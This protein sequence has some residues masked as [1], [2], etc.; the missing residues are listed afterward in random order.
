M[1]AQ[2][3]AAATVGEAVASPSVTVASAGAGES[4]AAEPAPHP[5]GRSA[6]EETVERVHRVTYLAENSKSSPLGSRKSSKDDPS[7]VPTAPTSL[8]D[9]KG[10]GRER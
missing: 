7:A 2:R 3:E 6:I 10:K 8:P 4:D 9:A 1:S 5:V